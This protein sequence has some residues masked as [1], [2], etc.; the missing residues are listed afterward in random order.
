MAVGINAE[1]LAALDVSVETWFQAHRSRK[2]QVEAT[3]IY[4]FLGEPVYAASA[5]VVCGTLLALRAR[6][7]IP[8]FLVVG[9]VGIGFVVVQVL[10]AMVG[11]TSTAVV[12]LQ[13]GMN[14]F[15]GVHD[16]RSLY[17]FAHTF[18]SGHLTGSVALLGMIAVCLGVGR[19][20]V[21]KVALTVPVVAGVLFVALLALLSM[22][23]PFT[24]VIGGMILGGAIVSLGAA[25]LGATHHSRR[26][27][28]AAPTDDPSPT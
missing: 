24:D 17:Q 7:A 23:H 10:K 25:V 8:G 14:L 9:G 16:P 2:R 4:R 15:L 18:P 27:S 28:T 1:W 22:A 3:E 6:S 11:R 21:V 5:G 20:R 26:D 19:S 12:E 13:F